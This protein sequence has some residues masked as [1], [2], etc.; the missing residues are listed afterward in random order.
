MAGLPLRGVR[1][2]KHFAWL[3]VG[4]IKMALSRPTNTPAEACGAEHKPSGEH[5]AV[6]RGRWSHCPIQI[7]LSRED[8]LLQ[9]AMQSSPRGSQ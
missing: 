2:F 5:S 9:A 7:D 4:S 1:A 8:C 3:A 6:P